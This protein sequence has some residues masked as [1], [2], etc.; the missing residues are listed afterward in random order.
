MDAEDSIMSTYHISIDQANHAA[1]S[2]LEQIGLIDPSEKQINAIE[3]LIVWA[4][5]PQHL[6]L[7]ATKKCL[8]SDNIAWRVLYRY[9]KCVTNFS[10]LTQI[11]VRNA[12]QI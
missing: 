1:I 12:N 2:V 8:D 4:M 7:I 9:L 10:D 11:G 5:Q 6:N 3:T